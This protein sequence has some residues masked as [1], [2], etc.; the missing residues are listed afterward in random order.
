MSGDINPTI[1]F[2]VGASMTENMNNHVENHKL[3]LENDTLK[4]KLRGQSP[5]G[6]AARDNRIGNASAEYAK[7][8]NDKSDK[9]IE[10]SNQNNALRSQVSETRE[11]AHAWEERAIINE[12]QRDSW[13]S[14]IKDFLT[15]GEINIT[16]E[17][18]N[19]RFNKY[20]DTLVESNLTKKRAKRQN[21]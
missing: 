19:K 9:I 20:Y 7:V 21:F 1:A 17:D 16:K 10:L 6:I 14:V 2:L 11:L 4:R 18:V 5:S 3:G 12:S 8:L 13:M 15:A